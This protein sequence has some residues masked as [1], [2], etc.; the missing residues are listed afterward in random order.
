MTEFNFYLS[1]D[2]ARLLFDK[3]ELRG[4]DEL[5]GNEF[6]KRI[7]EEYLHQNGPDFLEE[8]MIDYVGRVLR[9]QYEYTQDPSTASPEQ[10]SYYEGMFEMA[11][12]ILKEKI[13]DHK[14]AE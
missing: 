10:Q 3:K 14:P 13:P 9:T 6:A 1:D 5:T 2:D 7:I 12:I 8:G 4:L 11:R